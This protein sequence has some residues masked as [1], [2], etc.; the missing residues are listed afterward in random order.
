[1]QLLAR[2]QWHAVRLAIILVLLGAIVF[3]QLPGTNAFWHVLQKL[4]HSLIFAII[5]WLT[6]PVLRAVSPRAP[7]AD[8]ALYIA[9]LAIAVVLG[10]ATEIAQIF[11]HRDASLLDVG[12]DA[13]G[14]AAALAARCAIEWPAHRRVPAGKFRLL[15][16][17]GA[18]ALVAAFVAPMALCLAA[19]AH[20]DLEFPTLARFD[21]PLDLYFIRQSDAGGGRVPEPKRWARGSRETA[22]AIP[23]RSNPYSGI[24][25]EEPYPDWRGHSTLGFDLTNPGLAPLQLRVR[26]DDRRRGRGDRDR[27]DRDFILPAGVRMVFAIPLRDIQA[28]PAGPPMDMG[29][30]ARVLLFRN[31]ASVSDALLLNRIWLE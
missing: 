20:R 10:G 14:A 8:T 31:R 19:Y 28:G 13:A 18:V 16:A 1:M 29:H 2:P 17:G 21:S 11:V 27:F 4:G 22:L 12:R 9:A 23:L 25:L 5:A 6:V 7:G 26:V 15:C 24:A 30:I 3:L